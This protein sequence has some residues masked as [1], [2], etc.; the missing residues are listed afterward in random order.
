MKYNVLTTALD[1]DGQVL[2]RSETKCGN[3]TQVCI[4]I[5]N[6]FKDFPGNSEERFLRI[7]TIISK[8][9]GE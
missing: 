3:L 1:R 5:S 9:E 7:Q 2:D 6:S 4:C 8:E